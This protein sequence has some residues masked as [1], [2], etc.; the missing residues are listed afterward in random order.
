MH[1]AHDAQL[2]ELLL[3]VNAYV[4]EV[5]REYA[6][7]PHEEQRQRGPC[8]LDFLLHCVLEHLSQRLP[9][10]KN[11]DA[12]MQA[13]TSLPFAVRDVPALAKVAAM[14]LRLTS[15]VLS[16]LTTHPIITLFDLEEWV[17]AVEGVDTFAALGLGVGLQVLP[18]VQ[19]YFQLRPTTVVFP[20]QTRDVLSFVVSDPD[21]REVLLYG[22]GDA[23]DLLNRFSHF[24]E[25]KLLSDETRSKASR[26]S[27]RVQN[28]RQLGVHVQDYAAFV[29]HLAQE[30]AAGEAAAQSHITAATSARALRLEKNRPL[31]ER[32]VDSL[33]ASCAAEMTVAGLRHTRETTLLASRGS[34][35]VS[36]PT[37]GACGPSPCTASARRLDFSVCVTGAEARAYTVPLTLWGT[38][39]STI[40]HPK[41]GVELHFHVGTDIKEPRAV[42]G[43]HDAASSCAPLAAVHEGL[44]ADTRAE[45]GGAATCVA[46]P[47]EGV[48]TPLPTAAAPLLTAPTAAVRRR[49]GTVVSG[50]SSCAAPDT[51]PAMNTV[52]LQSSFLPSSAAPPSGLSPPLTTPAP[53]STA[54]DALAALLR[55]AGSLGLAPSGAAPAAVLSVSAQDAS[56]GGAVAAVS[57]ADEAACVPTPLEELCGFVDAVRASAD[58]LTL[59]ERRSHLSKQL[60][61]GVGLLERLCVGDVVSVALLSVVWQTLERAFDGHCGAAD[62]DTSRWRHRRFI[63]LLTSPSAYTTAQGPTGAVSRLALLRR[64]LNGEAGGAES[65]AMSAADMADVREVLYMASPAEVCWQAWVPPTTTA[66]APSTSSALRVLLSCA[67]L[68]QQYP[69]T[70]QQVLCDVFGVSAAPTVAAWCTAA[71]CVRRVWA[72]R[73]LSTDV[74]RMYLDSFM[75]C[76]EADVAA[77]LAFFPCSSAHCDRR[78]ACDELKASGDAE[79]AGHD[80]FH[81]C[82]EKAKAAAA[83][84]ATLDSLRQ[85]LA[86]TSPH[87]AGLFPCNNAWRC[88]LDGLLYAPPRLCGYEGVLVEAAGTDSTAAPRLP[89]LCFSATAPSWAVCAVLHCFGVRPLE[90]LLETRVGLSSSPDTHASGRLHDTVAALLPYVQG[91]LRSRLPH[92]YAVAYEPLLQRMQRLKVVLTA[93]GA[94]A[95]RQ[96]LRLHWEGHVYAYD[97]DVR[98]EYVAAHN[99]LFGSAEAYAVPM[100]TEALLPLFTPIAMAGEAERQQ[101]RDVVN[102]LLGAVSSL[103]SSYEEDERS[104]E[105]HG[106]AL[107]AQMSEVLARVAADQ[108]LPCF[109]QRQQP[110]GSS[111]ATHITALAEQPFALS[112]RPFQR[113]QSFFPPGT[114]GMRQPRGPPSAA[115]D[116]Q[117]R[118]D[119]RQQRQSEMPRQ[120]GA[121]RNAVQQ[122]FGSDGRLRIT[123]T[124][125][126]SGGVRALVTSQPA[127]ANFPM[128]LN[129]DAVVAA[130]SATRTMLDRAAASFSGS[131]DTDGEGEEA[132]TGEEEEDRS[133]GFLTFQYHRQKGA[134]TPRAIAGASQQTLK[135]SRRDASASASSALS[136]TWWL[137]PPAP[138]AGLSGGAGDT[139]EYAVAAERHVYELLCAEYADQVARQGVRVIW[140]NEYTEAGSPFDILVVRPRSVGRHSS[141]HAS[142]SSNTG[143]WDVVV[144][145]EVKSTCTANRADFELSLSELLFAARFGAAYKVYRVFG[146]STDALRRMRCAVYADLVQMWYRAELTVT[147]DIRVTPSR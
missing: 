140:V 42:R 63:P 45:S 57:T 73:P 20:V 62:T 139:P 11:G 110:Q 52:D 43:V 19:L 54:R 8:T 144:Y 46:S 21:A 94:S 103:A 92:W 127:W 76:V 9:H 39:A 13:T 115:V 56:G 91:F 31:Y 117:H 29:A 96:L 120:H 65:V 129:L 114:D 68:E 124:L 95:P 147:S 133:E 111:T 58:L 112:S 74:V 119:Q 131:S 126:S 10:E 99:I 33:D 77:R 38:A 64:R 108:R 113:F 7:L 41:G 125:P 48:H 136:S 135:R 50:V 14:Q 118:T 86:G 22:G 146:A 15:L 130:C 27:G 49:R 122:R 1:A 79:V 4:T 17:C 85:S 55:P 81:L 23:R 28:V 40:D 105:A 3:E 98:L 97:R 82:Y 70:C 36:A 109:Q 121:A 66:A 78:A 59:D 71:S 80:E 24:Y 72:P 104:A 142:T 32:V 107:V 128:E 67:C 2:G 143:E 69:Q 53:A 61:I 145:V 18:V 25:R 12:L 87:R 101:L 75:A 106:G 102:S 137:R 5:Q 37:T 123:L 93:A 47:A 16:A 116:R 60:S 141:V 26:G 35:G 132:L 100:L 89:V 138:S 83:L 30:V 134:K 44:G 34:D 6:Q 88:G 51:I 84:K 90:Q